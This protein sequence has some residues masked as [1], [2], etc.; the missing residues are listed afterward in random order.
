MTAPAQFSANLAELL[1]LA[2]PRP[3]RWLS[4]PPATPIAVQGVSGALEETQPGFICVLPGEGASAKS[5]RLAVQRGAAALVL[6]GEEP[7]AKVDWTPGL[8]VAL[9]EQVDA[10][11]ARQVLQAV[12]LSQRAVLLERSLRLNTQL[13]ELAS[14]GEG[15]PSL[16]RALANA[17]GHGVLLQDKRGEI[18]AEHPAPSMSGIW[19]DMLAHLASLESLPESL[20]DRKQAAQM[21]GTLRQ[22]VPG[23]L[24]RLVRPISV[25]QM[26]RGYLSLVGVAGELDA[27]DQVVVEQGCI[28]CAIEMSRDKAV[29]EAEKRLKGDLLTALLSEILAPRDASLW[30]QSMELNPEQKH[31]ALRFAWDAPSPP[32]RRRLETLV[33][34]E[35][36]RLDLTV[37]VSSMGAEVVCFCELPPASGRPEAALGLGQ[38][39][40]E[41]AGREYPEAPVRCGVGSAAGELSAWRDS[42]RQAGQALEMARRLGERK[43]LFFPDLS[44]YRLLMQIEHNPE[45]IAF[46]EETLGPLLAHEAGRELLH[47]LEAYFEHNGNLSQTAE[48]LFVHRNTLLYRMERIAEILHTELD[49][50]DV[51]LA[52]Q[53]G[54]MIYRMRARTGEN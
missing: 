23:G 7:Q 30:L 3:L 43:P 18:L 24:E 48:A 53:L 5:A 35:V 54:L 42:F 26:A 22:E 39:V 10:R 32:S 52:L 33:N 15:L 2:F 13:L 28:V 11:Q 46:Q 34:G 20:R 47:T 36:A 8:P 19:R 31:A 27:L 25:K 29:R 4:A 9:A 45:L 21:G 38:A 1:R 41:Q 16:A 14:Q 44:V 50:P 17:S 40:L 37:I 49:K 51:R 6:A 12:L